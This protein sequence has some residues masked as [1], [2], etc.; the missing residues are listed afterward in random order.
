MSPFCVQGRRT[1]DDERQ[2]GRWV[3]C[4]GSNGRWRRFLIRKIFKT[5]DG[6]FGD[7]E[8]CPVVRQTLQHW[9]YVLTEKDFD[10][11]VEERFAGK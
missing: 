7:P 2:V 11:G 3:R 8:I 1:D 10:Q 6:S 9:A 5:P 4:A